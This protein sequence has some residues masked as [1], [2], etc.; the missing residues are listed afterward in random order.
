MTWNKTV[1]LAKTSKGTWVRCHRHLW[2]D[3]LK[4]LASGLFNWHPLPPLLA[5]DVCVCVFLDVTGNLQRQSGMLLCLSLLEEKIFAFVTS[6]CDEHSF[7]SGKKRSPDHK[8]S[9]REFMTT[10]SLPSSYMVASFWPLS[11]V[12]FGLCLQ[13]IS[14]SKGFLYQHHNLLTP[15]HFK[16]K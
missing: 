12:C 4:F 14:I 8:S 6:S 15:F 1:F 2:S 10:F 3:N 9:T 7:G 16:N 5:S 11:F 13:S